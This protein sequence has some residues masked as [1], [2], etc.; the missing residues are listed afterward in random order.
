MLCL[1]GLLAAAI[2]GVLTGAEEDFLLG[3]VAVFEGI[4]QSLVAA[5][6]GN[7]NVGDPAVAHTL[8]EVVPDFLRGEDLRVRVADPCNGKI[9]SGDVIPGM[10]DILCRVRC[11]R[12]TGLNFI[13][14]DGKANAQQHS[15]GQNQ[16][17]Y[18]Q[19]FS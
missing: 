16:A 3:D 14:A 17:D 4:F 12:H 18:G 19:D 15:R 13:A 2:P 6:Q 10:Y 8:I 11:I 9:Q 7:G 5:V 1:K